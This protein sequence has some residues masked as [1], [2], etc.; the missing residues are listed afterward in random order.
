MF[1]MIYTLYTQV[2][3]KSFQKQKYFKMSI[4]YVNTNLFKRKQ[5]ETDEQSAS[6]RAK[7]EQASDNQQVIHNFQ[8]YWWKANNKDES[9]RYVCIHKQSK[10]CQASITISKDNK[11][12]RCSE[13]HTNHPPMSDAEVLI[14]RTEQELKEQ[15][16]ISILTI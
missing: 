16:I 8:R 9:K 6:K 3:L 1:K 10:K 14:Y 12:L 11:V 4:I 2:K 13:F 15:V 5:Q 7:T